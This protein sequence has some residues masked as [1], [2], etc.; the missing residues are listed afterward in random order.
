MKNKVK[1]NDYYVFLDTGYM[2]KWIDKLGIKKDNKMN[3]SE[4]KEKIE[5]QSETIRELKLIIK[6]REDIIQQEKLKN[7]IKLLEDVGYL[8]CETKIN[9]GCLQPTE[10][11]FKLILK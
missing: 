4:L 5:S 7:A 1:I 3:K 10:Y 6:E 11:K 2:L 8:E 9:F